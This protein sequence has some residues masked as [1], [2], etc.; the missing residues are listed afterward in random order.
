MIDPDLIR[1]SQPQSRPTMA[2]Q[3]II[4]PN[5]RFEETDAVGSIS[6]PSSAPFDHQGQYQEAFTY[7]PTSAANLLSG[8]SFATANANS[9]L[10]LPPILQSHNAWDNPTSAEPADM[11]YSRYQRSHSAESPCISEAFAP[12]GPPTPY[13][14]FMAMP[15]T[16]NSS[17]GPE[18]AIKR[19][20]P[21]PGA[22]YPAPDLRRCSVQAILAERGFTPESQQ[23]LLSPMGL[24]KHLGYTLYGYDLGHPDLDTPKNDD[25]NA[26][27]S[28]RPQSPGQGMD[29]NNENTYG[30]VPVRGKDMAFEQGRYYAKPVP[31]SVC[32]AL[33]PLPPLLLDNP[34]NLLYFHH[35]LNHTARILVPHDCEQN[36]FRQILPESKQSRGSPAYNF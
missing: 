26:I 35:F 12:S 8:A 2:A 18:D 15:L 11:A 16:P 17:V 19:T 25:A 31:I 36:P 5:S 27:A 7:P 28:L 4:E 13:T 10:S 24:P 9:M 22:T 29:M 33:E 14:P 20:A 32:R 34:M 3:A 23:G 30:Y 1:I 6:R 21:S